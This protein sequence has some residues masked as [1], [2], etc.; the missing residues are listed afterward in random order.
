MRG[1]LVAAIAC[2][3]LALVGTAHAQSGDEIATAQAQFERGLAAM[4]E[5]QFN[6]GC[7]A[8][9]ESVRLDPR[10]GAIFTLAECEAQWG[11]LASAVAHYDDY[12]ERFA[13]MNAEQQATQRAR[14][15]IAEERSK[16]LRVD[17]PLLTIELPAD[18]PREAVVKRDGVELGRA[19]LGVAL[20][21]DPGAHSV[22]VFVPGLAPTERL[23]D[24]APG[25]RLVV[26]LSTPRSVAPTILEPSPPPPPSA[27]SH[28]L[29]TGS[30]VAFGVGAAGLA[31]GAIAG[32]VTL[33]HKSTI[34]AHC[35]GTSCDRTGKEA[36]DSA[37][38]AAVVSSI[39]FGVAGVGAVTGLVLLLLQPSDPAPTVPRAAIDVNGDRATLVLRGAW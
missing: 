7:P 11:K 34:D 28:A 23:V 29:R 8:L 9:A 18:A 37:K 13:R 39:G 17:V 25:Q 21:V 2:A 27:P 3:Y 19:S 22:V 20:P 26:T 32:A 36:A 16:A 10:P 35:R 31:L 14:A 12:L 5:K 24:I 33:Q 1:R 4:A 15:K 38:S 6:I 30:Y